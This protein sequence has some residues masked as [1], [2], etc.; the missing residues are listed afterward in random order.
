MNLIEL[1]KQGVKR[2]FLNGFIESIDY[3][4]SIGKVEWCGEQK[5]YDGYNKLHCY[6][7][8]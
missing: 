6:N 7:S 3:V 8:L 2:V 1:K 4:I 5:T